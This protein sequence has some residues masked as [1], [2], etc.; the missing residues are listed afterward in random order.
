MEGRNG[1][2]DF[3]LQQ[4]DILHFLEDSDSEFLEM[5][6]ENGG[7]GGDDDDDD[8]PVKGGEHKNEILLRNSWTKHGRIDNSDWKWENVCNNPKKITIS[9]VSRV[10]ERIERRFEQNPS[11]VDVLEQFLTDEFWDH[12]ARETNIHAER[13]LR[14]IKAGTENRWFPVTSDELKA[15]FALCVLMSQVKKPS[16][17]DYWTKRKILET[18]VFRETMPFS[19]FRDINRYLHFASDTENDNIDR[20]RKVKPIIKFLQEKYRNIY[21]PGQN[22]AISE[23]VMKFREIQHN[24]S[25]RMAYGLKIYKLCETSTGYCWNFKVYQGKDTDMESEVGEVS[26]MWEG[27][28]TVL[29]LCERLLNSGRTIYMDIWYSSPAL[30]KYLLDRDTHAIGS[31]WARRKCMPATWKDT[32]L[33]RGELTFASANGILAVKWRHKKDVHMLST[34]HERPDMEET[35]G[36]DGGVVLK[37]NCVVEYI[38]V[39]GGV[40][41]HDQQL[42][43]FP[44]VRRYCQGYKKLYFYLLDMTMLNASIIHRALNPGKKRE[45]YTSFRVNIAEEILLKIKLPDYPI[46]G[47]LSQGDKPLR[48]Q[49]IQWAHF[50]SKI[51]PTSKKTAPSRRCKVCS[52]RGVR[53]ETCYECEQ[54]KIA[55][56]VEDCFKIYHTSALL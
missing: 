37:P 19:R 45:R 33:E 26:K 35:G 41:A 17:Q 14:D 20:L 22:I 56:H 44:I 15:H 51:P 23:S 24:S 13:S 48:L 27:E 53:K 12:I 29:K 16:L 55:L 50:P 6:S 47:R 54:C 36:Q 4:V 5:Q 42:A 43:S 8:D 21:V 32:K 34:K 7:G 38:S 30:F 39:M 31:V 1:T 9:A 18:P 11:E 40:Y 46:R 10:S 28:I 3:S 49:S 52:T 2:A 25:K